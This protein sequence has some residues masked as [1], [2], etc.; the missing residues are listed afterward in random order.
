MPRNY[1]A[2]DLL[3]TSRGDYYIFNGDLMDTYN[4]P[5]RSL[6]QEIKT[7]ASCDQGA[8]KLY[9]ELGSNISDFVGEPNNKQTAEGIK[10]RIINSLAR[11]GFMHT[12][13][14]KIKYMPIDIDKLLLRISVSVLPT[15]DNAGSDT[16]TIHGLYNYE[17]DQI[18]FII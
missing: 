11:H 18:S 3:W 7:R 2:N 4:D 8:W 9:P 12:S 15:A 1:D 6:V 13:D 14:I 5:L 16:L 17:E 10:T